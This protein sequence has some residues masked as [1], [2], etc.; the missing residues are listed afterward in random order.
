MKK[1][2]ALLA[3]LAAILCLLVP[4]DA[5]IGDANADGK[6]T[7]GDARTVLRV[8]MKL[9]KLPVERLP[10]CD[11][12]HNGV[13]TVSDAR[14]VLRAAIGLDGF[15]HPAYTGEEPVVSLLP[16][17]CTA[18]GVLHYRCSCGDV[19]AVSV[20][21]KGH[22][23]GGTVRERLIRP[24]CVN[25]GSYDAVVYCSACK[26]ELSRETHT[27]ARLPHTP[28]EAVEENYI[29]ADVDL[30]GSC[31][32]VVYCRDCGAELSRETVLLEPLPPLPEGE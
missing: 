10:V 30:P 12:D 29:P 26:A 28:G 24:T 6:L 19:F 25:E 17:T 7:V 21:A 13:I 22:M 3:S 5:A 11:A 27:A 15:T 20:P 2:I 23:P 9:Q 8:A 16:A 14:A 31:D 4:A 18:S 1:I 32:S